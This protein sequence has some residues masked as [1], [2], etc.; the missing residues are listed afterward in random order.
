ME[1]IGKFPTKEEATTLEVSEDSPVW[2][3]IQD[4]NVFTDEV[5]MKIRKL[6]DWME[7]GYKNIKK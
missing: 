7:N 3:N 5:R 6:S 4:V 2:I 1:V